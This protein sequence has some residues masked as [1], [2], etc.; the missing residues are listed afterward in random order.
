MTV[1]VRPRAGSD[2]DACARLL[3]EVHRTDGYPVEGVADP[4][5]WLTPA[6]ATGAWVGAFDRVVVGHALVCT[7]TDSDDAARLWI[8]RTAEPLTRVLVFGRLFVGAEGRKRGVGER[9]V[10]T[11]MTYA[12][13][14]NR[15]LV[16]DVMDKDAAAIRL[17]ERLGWQHIGAVTH[18][19]GAGRE[20]GAQCYAA[21]S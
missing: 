20:T 13:E 9:L 7:A 6:T 12:A 15:R 3:T 14:R 21:P 16:L 19:F 5:A 11:A 18:H 4:I 1:T 10:R 8:E 17:Y 2:L